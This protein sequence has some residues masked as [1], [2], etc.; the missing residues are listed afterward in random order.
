MRAG[1]PQLAALPPALLHA[2]QAELMGTGVDARAHWWAMPHWVP[3]AQL[4]TDATQQHHTLLADT[5]RHIMGELDARFCGLEMWIQRR[6]ASAAM[7]LHW[8]MDEERVRLRR[9]LRTP[10][11][12]VVVYLSDA[13]GPTVVLRQVPRAPRNGPRRCW[14]VWPHAGQVSKFQGNYLHGVLS[15]DAAAPERH[16]LILNFW[17]RRPQGLPRLPSVLLP[18]RATPVGPLPAPTRPAPEADAPRVRAWRLQ[19]AQEWPLQRLL[20]GSYDETRSVA[21]RLPPGDYAGLQLES[22]LALLQTDEAAEPD[23]E[24]E[25]ARLVADGYGAGEASLR[26][27]G[28]GQLVDVPAV[29]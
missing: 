19:E 9:Q 18:R 25:R 17:R 5:V 15:G 2:W 22:F 20:L 27:S 8:D 28:P 1:A 11:L 21:L 29:G 10:I 14:C 13:G 3:R 4:A 12:T 26:P 16:T 23:G 7:H 24:T 6:K